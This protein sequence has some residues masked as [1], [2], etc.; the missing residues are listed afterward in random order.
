MNE[1]QVQRLSL[2]DRDA[3][4]QWET[5]V[6]GKDASTG[7]HLPA[8][9]KIFKDAFG[10]DT[11]L[12]A[13]FRDGVIVG[14]LPLTHVRSLLFGSFLVSLPFVNYG[15]LLFDDPVG[16]QALV[17]AAKDLSRC[18]KTKS[19]ELRHQLPSGC[20]L[21]AKTDHKIS[22]VLDLPAGHALL[23][24]GFKD[25]VRNQVR[26]A[27]KGGLIIQK[28]RAHLLDDFYRVFCVNM[29]DLGTPVYAKSFFKAVLDHFPNDTQVLCV[30]S[31]GLCIAAGILYAY[32]NTL[33]M[34]WA[35][36]LLSHRNQCPNHLLYWEALKQAADAGFAHFDFGRST[37]GSGPWRFKKQWGTR[38]VPLHWEYILLDGQDVPGLS[39]SNPKF[40]LAISA[41]KKMPLPIAN[42]LGPTIVR[43]IP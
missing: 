23:W 33:Q 41:W 16:G 37:P 21:P 10:H 30:K 19:V 5:Y 13:A 35:S 29:R 28:G 6:R 22:M 39:T 26:K 1:I 34:P 15:G 8:W 42:F 27:Q 36:S 38:E 14:T 24:K 3:F 2:G 4:R 7:Y 17:D 32:G 9:P 18:L 20:N 11:Y 40:S 12:L 43:G 25:K 31:G